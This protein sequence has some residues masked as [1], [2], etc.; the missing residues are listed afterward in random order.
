M[1]V[2]LSLS[3]S[4]C[5]SVPIYGLAKSSLGIFCNTLWKNPN[6]PFGQHNIILSIYVPM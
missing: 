2:C 1:S 4:L 3:L 5:F 6:E